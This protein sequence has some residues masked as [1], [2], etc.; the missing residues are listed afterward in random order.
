MHS[1]KHR[2]IAVTVAVALLHVPLL[3]A[4]SAAA[5]DTT[6]DTA[7]QTPSQPLSSGLAVSV[8]GFRFEGN[9]AF[10][11][12]ELAGLLTEFTGRKL[13]T[14]DLES[15]RKTLTLHYINAGYINSGAVLPDQSV[16]DG[17]ILFRIVE[18]KMS[19]VV[20]SGNDRLNTDYIRKRIQRGASE[21]LSLL[22]LKDTLEVVRQNPNIS[23]INAE[24]KPGTDPGDS[25]LDVLVEEANQFHLG[26]KFSNERPASLGAERLELMMSHTNLTGHGDTLAI[27]WGVT[28][29]GLDE[30]K[31]GD[32]DDFTASYT[33]PITDN[34]A[35]LGFTYSRSDTIVIE[36]P[37]DTLDITSESESFAI[38]LR[39]PV[40]RKPNSEFALSVQAEHRKNE[41]FLLGDPFSFSPGAENGVTE[42]AAIRFVQEWVKRTQSHALAARSTISV[43]IDALGSTTHSDST[44]PD[45][46]FVAWL[47]QFQYIQRLFDTNNQFVLRLSGQVTDDPLLSME[48]FS[49]GGVDTVRGYREN[50]I[51]RDE[52]FVVS[53]ETRVPLIYDA[54]GRPVVTVV[55]FYDFGVGSNEAVGSPSQDISSAGLGLLINPNEHV[56]AK[57]YWGHPFRKI[58]TPEHDL[59]DIGLHFSLTLWAF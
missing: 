31:F 30:I 48:Q 20:I 7:E 50:Q 41:T 54:A 45:S 36:E 32:F 16:E 4:D 57:I 47:G 21:P 27:Q 43:G 44:V 8:T 46:Q 25:T 59:Q 23:R 42:V 33:L 6:A 58:E 5:A 51:V 12:D 3:R 39:V 2:V 55:P 29:D 49:V 10:T 14:E 56:D 38:A 35:T 22:E 15:A 26:V 28:K 11:H 52:G 53:V 24:L 40:V 18:G 9:T 34:D 13:N 1:L 37:F 17:T 19:D